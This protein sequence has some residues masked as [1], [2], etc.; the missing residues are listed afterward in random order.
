M[1]GY[2]QASQWDYP[3]P[4]PRLVQKGDE[5]LIVPREGAE[6][7]RKVDFARLAEEEEVEEPAS[8]PGPFPPSAP[9]SALRV[10]MAHMA[11]YWEDVDSILDF[12]VVEACLRGPNLRTEEHEP[13]PIQRSEISTRSK[14]ILPGPIAG[15]TRISV[16]KP[17]D[18]I[19]NVLPSE[20]ALL[21]K[22]PQAGLAN[23]LFGKPLVVEH[24]IEKDRIPKHRVLVCFIV[25]AY[26]LG[27][28]QVRSS[29][30]LHGYRHDYVY[31]KRQVFD[32]L[33]DLREAEELIRL[34]TRVEIDVALFA[35][36]PDREEAAACYKFSLNRIQDRSG[37]NALV[38]RLVQLISLANVAPEFFNR[39]ASHSL[40]RKGDGDPASRLVDPHVGRYLRREA[41]NGAYR[42]INIVPIGLENLS[43]FIAAA[44]RYFS[45]ESAARHQILIITPDT[46]L[47]DSDPRLQGLDEP[48]WKIGKAQTLNQTLRLMAGESKIM[49]L[50]ALRRHFCRN[51]YR[52]TQGNKSG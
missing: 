41:R 7:A 22:H 39:A 3:Q 14:S 25:D 32:L 10:F 16:K 47:A 19:Y 5:V 18:P 49:E 17:D 44:N 33:R 20:M 45:F 1:G 24:E 26:V 13:P 40:Q 9:I 37:R 42:T 2:W 15:V 21:R 11:G 51:C 38:D 34:R 35:M 28:K 48:Q 6:A 46:R 50:G 8:D 27:S 23:L 29:S 12:E 52:R 30:V 31:A 36:S 43:G 4:L